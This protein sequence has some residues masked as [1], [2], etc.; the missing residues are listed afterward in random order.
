M[1][2]LPFLAEVLFQ[3]WW[4]G[5]KLARGIIFVIASAVLFELLLGAHPGGDDDP[6]SLVIRTMAMLCCLVAWMVSGIPKYR[7]RL[8]ARR[9]A[10]A[11]FYSGFTGP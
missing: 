5:G 11:D 9:M 4:N 7:L 2:G 1:L 6:Y 3:S 8:R 10:Y